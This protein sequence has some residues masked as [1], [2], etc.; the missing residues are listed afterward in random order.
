ME[1]Q[2]RQLAILEDDG[3]IAIPDIPGEAVG[4]DFTLCVVGTFITDRSYNFNAMRTQLANIWKPG[5]GIS[6]EDRG[7]GLV[8]F[9]FHHPLDLKLVM[10]GG[11]WS[12][13]N[14]LLTMHELRPGDD[15]HNVP[16][17]Y[18]TFWVQIYD[19]TADFYSETV[20]RAIGNW[21]GEFIEYDEHNHFTSLEPCMR[22]R[23][24]LDV[25]KSLK[26]EKPVKKAHKEITVSFRYEKLPT[27][28]F[29]CGRIG[30]I[31]RYCE[32]RY[33]I[34]E[35]QI[36][37]LWDAELRAPLR[38]MKPVMGSR[39][40][41]PS[42]ADLRN[43]E[44]GRRLEGIR[45]RIP[46]TAI[47]PNK[48]ANIQALAVN[49]RANKDNQ[50]RVWGHVPLAARDENAAVEVDDRKRRRG[51]ATTPASMEIDKENMVRSTY[52]EGQASK[53]LVQAGSGTESCQPR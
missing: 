43:Q 13:D 41:T 10:E 12:F 50:N 32:V 8:L 40:L 28:C 11:P 53:N 33:R 1:E 49:F 34:P 31:D 42:P 19:L 5:R 27:F 51:S 37:K 36:V 14:N 2:L 16:L 23:V 46:L 22:I 39:W 29:V 17:M 45:G 25:R 7:E 3:E 30:H 52:N 47:P 18:A 15:I 26:R 48:P 35:D 20:G 21:M 9:R 6:I 38:R 44:Q 4:D 24:R